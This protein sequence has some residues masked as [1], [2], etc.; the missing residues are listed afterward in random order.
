MLSF[1]I[2]DFLQ[3]NFLDFSRDVTFYS[4]LLEY[5]NDMYSNKT[6][7]QG[8][9]STCCLTYPTLVSCRSQWMLWLM[10]LLRQLGEHMYP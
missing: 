1:K 4:E 6:F 10:V 3:F 9:C 2:N 5:W 8:S 7:F